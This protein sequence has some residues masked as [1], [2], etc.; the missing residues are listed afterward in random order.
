M[1]ILTGVNG[2]AA[3]VYDTDDGTNEMTDFLSLVARLKQGMNLKIYGLSLYDSKRMYPPDS[4]IN[5]QLGIVVIPSEA[6]QAYRDF[7]NGKRTGR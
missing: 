3:R 1:L 4:K 2:S 7:V 5:P 6:T